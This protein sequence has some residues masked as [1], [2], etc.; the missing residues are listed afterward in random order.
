M[1]LSPHQDLFW[2][3]SGLNVY[4]NHCQ[5]DSLQVWFR[6]YKSKNATGIP[7]I[8]FNNSSFKSLDLNPKTRTEIIDCYIDAK[9]KSQP[10]LIKAKNSHVVIQ[11][12]KFVLFI[13]ENGPTIIAAENNCWVTVENSVFTSHCCKQVLYLYGS[14]HMKITNTTFNRNRAESVGGAIRVESHSRLVVTYC[15]F[16]YNS[17]W[18]GGAIYGRIYTLLEISN[19]IFLN[20]YASNDGGRSSSGIVYIY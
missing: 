14:S 9:N 5:L 15:Y 11:N 17:A 6:K 8:M 12:S 3:F 7:T 20:N 16:T 18:N 4:F 13:N 1:I 2:T 19:T 10:T